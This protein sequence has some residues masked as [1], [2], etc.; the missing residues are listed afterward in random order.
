[1]R[2][3]FFQA[4]TEDGLKYKKNVFIYVKIVEYY[5]IEQKNIYIYICN[6]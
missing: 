4:E 3:D 1:M 6:C 2:I 5:S